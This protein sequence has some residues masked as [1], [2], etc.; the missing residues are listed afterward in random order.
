M[1]RIEFR[2]LLKIGVTAAVGMM[3][4]LVPGAAEDFGPVPQIE[5]NAAQ[6]ELGRRLFF[7]KRLSGDAAISCASCHDP[8]RGFADGLPLSAAYP[9]SLGFRNTP[10]LINTAH[11][12]AWFHDGRLGSNLNDVT[13]EMITEDYMMNMDMRLMQER[14]KQDPVYVEM[15]EAAGYG[16]P[17]NGG[18][19]KAIPEFLKTLISRNSAFDRGELSPS[20][21]SG[22]TIFA[23][24]AGCGTCHS[25]P[26]FTDDR[27]YN[28]GVPDNPEIWRNPMRHTTF[29]AYAMF[30]GIENFMNIRRDP[31][32][33]V[34]GHAA[35]GSDV[36]T[37]LTPTL[38][39]LTHTGPYMHNGVFATLEEVIDFYD[40]GGG[41]DPNK[42][43]RLM[44]LG[45]SK[46]QRTDL[47]AFLRALSGDPL[48]G[49]E[50]V[51]QDPIP[52]EYDVID[53]W[54]ETP[55]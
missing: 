39:E 21:Q 14:F 5:T 46:Q 47:V 6:V 25:G 44:P 24:V 37:F 41:D 40:A 45:L 30:M 16:E 29:V 17:S 52:T 36:G 51:W 2:G 33:H 22:F 26:R 34:R 10:T 35:D 27:V 20:E 11:R 15:F 49:P 28:T 23:G 19:R 43:R 4:A 1:I 12:A 9:G 54:R 3:A 32:A 48:T 31:G 13:R 55:N 18:A 42:D 8:A 50:F 7:D 38:R 53:D